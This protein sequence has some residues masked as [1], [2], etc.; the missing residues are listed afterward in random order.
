MAVCLGW[1]RRENFMNTLEKPL[2]FVAFAVVHAGPQRCAK[3]LRVFKRTPLQFA[4]GRRQKDTARAAIAGMGLT[5]NQSTLLEKP[6]DGRNG[7]WIRGSPFD[8]LDL[9]NTRFAGHD[10][11]YDIL[12]GSN[13]V[14]QH[15]GIDA[16]V[17]RKIGL[18]QPHRQLMAFRHRN[19]PSSIIFGQCAGRINGSHRSTRDDKQ[20]AEFSLRHTI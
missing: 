8:D 12:I 9:R 18:A 2:V 7:V 17:E 13:A 15:P 3:W 1:R 4:P 14:I 5:I 16:A 6:Q 11:K 20:S 10:A 19:P